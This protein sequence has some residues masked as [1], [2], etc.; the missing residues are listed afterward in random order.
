M[1]VP[2]LILI[3][4]L[5][6]CAALALPNS[7]AFWRRLL[8]PA[9]GA[10][11]LLL[12][13]TA[14]LKSGVATTFPPLA[15]WIGI[16][17]LGLVFLW[18]IGILFLA[19]TL[20]FP[21]G[22]ETSGLARAEEGRKERVRIAC[23]LFALA[24]L[25][26]ACAAQ[27]LAV[28]GAAGAAAVLAG[29]LPFPRRA[30]SEAASTPFSA[31][32][33]RS[34]A[35]LA[36]VFLAVLRLCGMAGNA[37]VD[38]FPGQ[39]LRIAGLFTMAVAAFCLPRQKDVERLLGC[40]AIGQAGILAFAAGLGGTGLWAALLHMMSAV[41]LVAGLVLGAGNIAR[42]YGTTSLDAITGLRNA[43]PLTGALWLA[44]VLALGG[45]PPFGLFFS[46]FAVARVAFASDR[47]VQGALF[48]VFLVALF[49][50]MANPALAMLRG[51]P[52]PEFNH[53]AE[54]HAVSSERVLAILPP[55]LL[56]ALILL[57][58][59]GVPEFVSTLLTEATVVVEPGFL[60][61]PGVR[62]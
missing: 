62:P 57:L 49:L 16:D 30:A 36:A 60:S 1:I 18:V 54:D 43:M 15:D 21:A 55:V 5:A 58:G 34:G 42:R 46:E 33:L 32:A 13:G 17:A 48:L 35:A 40:A 29:I 50:G 56:T 20:S 23:L 12:V 25:S 44:G 39:L 59:F 10:A 27:S 51:G 3:P 22:P 6:G 37:G 53:D 24:A 38:G 52:P 31:G 8:A 26:C 14:T 41:F 4:L 61:P 47:Y 7:L 2:A 19:T 45:L 9:T 11:H 28:F